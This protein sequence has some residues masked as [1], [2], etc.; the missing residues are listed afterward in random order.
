MYCHGSTSWKVQKRFLSWMLGSVE[1]CKGQE[2]HSI[3]CVFG[4][5]LGGEVWIRKHMIWSHLSICY[6]SSNGG[7]WGMGQVMAALVSH[8]NYVGLSPARKSEPLKDF[9][10]RGFMVNLIYW[11]LWKRQTGGGEELLVPLK[12]CLLIW[13]IWRLKILKVME[14]YLDQPNVSFGFGVVLLL[15]KIII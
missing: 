2:T 6:N 11:Q 13:T 14:S 10:Q 7:R 9:W 15:S 1:E 8:V 5:M 3:L 4:R 12:L